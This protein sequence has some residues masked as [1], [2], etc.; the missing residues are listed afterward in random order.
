MAKQYTTKTGWFVY[1]LN[2]DELQVLRKLG[3]FGNRCDNCS[4]MVEEVYYIPVLNLAYC[5]KCF[6]G[7]LNRAE[8]FEEDA[9]F[10]DEMITKF[11]MICKL[12]GIDI[13][14]IHENIN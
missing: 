6:E 2:N 5:T 7:W 13:E 9:W 1:H 8:Y 14:Q 10:E 4:R 11:G 3:A 12:V